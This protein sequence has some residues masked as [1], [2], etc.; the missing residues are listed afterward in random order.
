MTKTYN[1]SET[2]NLSQNLLVT[3]LVDV[4]FWSIWK[5]LLKEVIDFKFSLLH[6]LIAYRETH[7]LSS[8]PAP[9]TPLPFFEQNLAF[10]DQSLPI[11][12]KFV[13]PEIQTLANICSRDPSF[14]PKKSVPETLFLKTWAGQT[15]PNFVD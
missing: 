2:L 1:K 5:S 9:E 12:T 6:E 3:N 13:A 7:L 11:L 4:D 14:K 10:Q 8:F 15:D